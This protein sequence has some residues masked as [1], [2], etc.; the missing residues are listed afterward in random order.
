MNVPAQLKKKTP[1]TAG[2][3]G[4]AATMHCGFKAFILCLVFWDQNWTYE[5]D[6]AYFTP[7]EL[8]AALRETDF[9]QLLEP[10]I[11]III[12]ALVSHK[13]LIILKTLCPHEQN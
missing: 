5:D 10:T 8:F 13:F 7:I 9:H 1:Q 2:F 3:K 11:M 6:K 4:H 12:V